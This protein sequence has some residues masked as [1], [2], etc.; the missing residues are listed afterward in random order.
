MVRDNALLLSVCAQFNDPTAKLIMEW[1]ADTTIITDRDDDRMWQEA[2]LRL[3]DP[4][5][6]RRIITFSKYADLGIESS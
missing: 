6:R 2:A 5:M 3:D 1:L 4:V